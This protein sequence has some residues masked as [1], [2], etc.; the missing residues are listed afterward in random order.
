VT[1]VAAREL[2]TARDKWLRDREARER[3]VEV[4][5][6]L[7]SPLAEEVR[8]LAEYSGA[9]AVNRTRLRVAGVVLLMLAAIIAIAATLLVGSVSPE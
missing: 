5:M 6:P 1:N 3:A 8:A 4:T 7:E 9:E 2:A